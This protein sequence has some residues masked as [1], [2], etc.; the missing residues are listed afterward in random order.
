MLSYKGYTGDLE[1]GESIIFGRVLGIQDVVTFKGESIAEIRQ[2]F[3]DSVDDY[4]EF[5]QS[6]GQEPEK[7]FSSKLRTDKHPT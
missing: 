1:V 7:A 3:Q 2:S 5:C 6:I 4:L